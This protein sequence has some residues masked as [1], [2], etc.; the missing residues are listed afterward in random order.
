MRGLESSERA[1]GLFLAGSI[2]KAQGTRLTG[3][4]VDAGGQWLWDW[5]CVELLILSIC[6]VN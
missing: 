2:N 3:E 5:E 1:E 6:L 4:E